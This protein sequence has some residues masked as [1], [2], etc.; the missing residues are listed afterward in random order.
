MFISMLV[1]DEWKIETDITAYEQHEN[2]YVL[3][4]Q[5]WLSRL[6]KEL[7]QQAP[8][9]YQFN[10]WESW[11]NHLTLSA[12]LCAIFTRKETEH[13]IHTQNTN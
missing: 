6:H 3:G 12:T 9:I 1:P 5:F 8:K 7:C 10:S 4:Y 11:R 13:A 2:G